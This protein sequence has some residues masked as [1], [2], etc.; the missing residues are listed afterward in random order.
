MRWC[1]N[2]GNQAFLAL[3]HNY[4]RAEAMNIMQKREIKWL[5]WRDPILGFIKMHS[6]LTE[7]E[8]SFEEEVAADSFSD[9][10][11][12]EQSVLPDGKLQGPVYQ[13]PQGLVPLYEGTMP[14]RYWNFWIGHTNFP[15][16][17][18]ESIALEKTPGVESLDIFTPYRFRVGIGMMFKQDEVKKGVEKAL[19]INLESEGIE[20]IKEILTKKHKF[21]SIVILP[22]GKTEC[23]G[24]KTK[25]EVE[26]RTKDIKDVC[27]I[28]SSW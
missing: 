26:S 27:K 1:K 11:D 8:K 14:S 17:K 28:V 7:E 4:N 3:Q 24:G 16:N 22:K 18:P 5:R 25:E 20:R 15:I 2:M 19:R 6:K 10:D 9:D 21:W 12:R 23:F 13:G